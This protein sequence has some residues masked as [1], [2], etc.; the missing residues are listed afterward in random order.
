MAEGD[1]K[2]PCPICREEFELK[3]QVRPK[4]PS[5]PSG[6]GRAQLSPGFWASGIPDTW[7]STDLIVFFVKATH[8]NAQI[9][10]ADTA[11]TASYFYA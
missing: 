6:G 7:A 10:P 4:S 9:L 8:S 3:P 2:R 1:S 5:G 11:D